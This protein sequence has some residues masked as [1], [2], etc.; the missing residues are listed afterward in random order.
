MPRWASRASALLALLLAGCVGE[1]PD[2]ARIEQAIARDSGAGLVL[3]VEQ[4]LGFPPTVLEALANGIPLRLAYSLQGCGDPPEWQAAHYIELRYA[5]LQRAY[6]LH[7]TGSPVRRFGRRSALVAALDRVRVPLPAGLPEG[8][9]GSIRVALDLTSLPTPLR[10]PALLFPEQWRL[11]SP[12]A[13]WQAAA[14]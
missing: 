12:L 9:Q 11:V 3:E 7:A 14:G 5:P 8:C 13:S 6:E 1:T 10:F 4:A 2:R